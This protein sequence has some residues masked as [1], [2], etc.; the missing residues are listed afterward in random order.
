LLSPVVEIYLYDTVVHIMFG[1]ISR[2]CRFCLLGFYR[3]VLLLGFPCCAFMQY[4]QYLGFYVLLSMCLQL[5]SSSLCLAN[6]FVFTV[7]TWIPSCCL[8]SYFYRAM[9][10]AS[11]YYASRQSKCVVRF[12]L[13]YLSMLVCH[14]SSQIMVC[15]QLNYFIFLLSL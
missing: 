15:F 4:N 12:H 5:S 2:I 14:F 10:T 11:L 1:R 7:C 13:K 8:Q 9:H 3:F 6:G